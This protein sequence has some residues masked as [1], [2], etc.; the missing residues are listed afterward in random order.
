MPD[1][2]QHITKELLSNGISNAFFNGIIC[3]YLIKD[4]GDMPWWGEHSFGVDILATALLL[5]WIVAMIVIPIQRSKVRK[6]KLSPWQLSP[7]M[8]SV[9]AFAHRF[10]KSLWLNGIAFGALGMLIVAPL[11]LLGLYMAGAELFTPMEYAIF[12]GVWAG[13]LAV[14]L[15]WLMILVGLRA[16]DTVEVNTAQ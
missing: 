3:W 12:K 8:S 14:S 15:V 10:P 1:Y 5:P 9:L 4:K 11:T 13:L 7:D 16:K 6:G 2:K